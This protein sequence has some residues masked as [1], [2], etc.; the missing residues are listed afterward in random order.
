MLCGGVC[1]VLDDMPR[2]KLSTGGAIACVQY[3]EAAGGGGVVSRREWL[4]L[5]KWLIT[6]TANPAVMSVVWL[7]Q[8]R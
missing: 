6:L 1:E 7:W 3:K 8:E 5:V 4:E 2:A